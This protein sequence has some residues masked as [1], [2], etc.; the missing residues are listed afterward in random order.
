VPSTV[1]VCYEGQLADYDTRILTLATLKGLFGGVSEDPV[2]YVNAPTLA[3]EH[4]VEIR[5]VNCSTPV[6]HM[7]L[8]TI[9]GGDH[10]IAGTLGGRRGESRI[11]VLDGHTTDVPPATNMLV[12]RNDDRPG[13][14]GV[15]GTALGEAGINIADMDV[16][17]TP[18]PGSAIMVLATTAPVPWPLIDQL[19]GTPGIIS[20]HPL[21]G[22]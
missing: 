19:R 6:D 21:S 5:E 1:E 16:G 18:M 17:R 14:I 2:T 15:V 9:R 13:M 3:K 10:E 22:D 11:V 8:I 20:V 7:N 4:G 12:V